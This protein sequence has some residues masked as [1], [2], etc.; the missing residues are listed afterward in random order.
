MSQPME[1][2]EEERRTPMPGAVETV[3]S[4][5]AP[6]G[7]IVVRAT[8]STDLDALAALFN[9]PGVRRGTLAMP[10]LATRTLVEREAKRTRGSVQVMS[11]CATL[12]SRVIGNVDVIPQ[13]PR[14]AH[15]AEIGIAVHD[16]HAGR[17][18][19]TALLAA[20]ITCA[21]QSLGLR[22]LEL[23]VFV[24]NAA[25]IALYRKFGF[26][27]EGRSRGYAMRDGVLADALH[28]ARYAE[29]PPFASPFASPPLN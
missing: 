5:H 25:A 28:M 1:E 18:V 21:D 10:F 26:V 15:C 22:R 8:Q 19:G 4:A 7:R 12:D 27:E 3:G 9:L 2:R 13:P 16:A 14:R 23:R 20:A 29:A 11:F 17:G 6:R 24:D